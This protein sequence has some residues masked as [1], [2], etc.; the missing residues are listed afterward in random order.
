MNNPFITTGYAGAYYF[1]DR[2]KETKD[3]ISLLKNGNNLAL[4]SPRRVGKTDLLRHCLSHNELSEDYYSFIIDI[5][6]TRNLSDFVNC[7][8]KVILE[9]LKPKGK[10]AWS[11]FTNIISSLK[12]EISYDA[13]G[14]PS[15]SVGIGKITN[16]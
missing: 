3:I 12:S 5:Y 4:I 16:H 1:C 15:W 9:E 11:E 8:G 10:K 6:S 14:L 2:E 13:N 7:I